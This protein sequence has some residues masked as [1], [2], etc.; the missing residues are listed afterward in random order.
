MSRIDGVEIFSAT[1]VRAREQLGDR[2]TEWREQNR[3]VSIVDVD[4]RQ[5][6]DAAYHCLTIVLWWA[7][8]D[9]E[10]AEET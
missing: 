9:N 7:E 10:G 3:D 6:S 4:V 5:S 1:V 2:V 8:K